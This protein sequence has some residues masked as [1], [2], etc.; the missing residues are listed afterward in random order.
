MVKYVYALLYKLAGR[1]PRTL[2]GR[3]QLLQVV[4]VDPYTVDANLPVATANIEHAISVIEY[5]LSVDIYTDY[6]V[7]NNN[8]IPT[9]R[10]TYLTDW[11]TADLSLCDHKTLA[12]WLTG[13]AKLDDIV[14][15]GL[16]YDRTDI[17]YR[18]SVRLLPVV[19]EGAGIVAAMLKLR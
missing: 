9:E 17:I 3:C 19:T 6:A 13:L 12:R 5:A 2:S 18:N 1:I 4:P 10:Y 14:T 15:K 16:K 11:L 8:R 7:G